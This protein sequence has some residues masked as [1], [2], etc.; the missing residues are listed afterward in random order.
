V[1]VFTWGVVSERL[2][3]ADVTA[4][5]VFLGIGAAMVGTDLGDAEPA[6]A[7]L[8]PL[9][10]ITLVWVLFSD[11]ARIR[12]RD[13]RRDA[14]YY[15]RLLGVGLPLSVGL[16][17]ALAGWLLPGQSVWLALLIGAALAPTDAA[18]GLPVVTNPAVP[19]RVRRAII[20]ESGLNDGIATPIVMVALAGAASTAGLAEAPT[21]TGAVLELIVGAAVG[22]AV[23]GLGGA[24]LR[25]GRRRGWVAEEFAGIAVLALA[26][27]AYGVTLLAG[28]NGFVA[29]F[30]GGV[31]FGAA[32]GRRASG[33]LE[34]IEQV[35]GVASL[36]VW[37]VF[38]AIAAPV[39]VESFSVQVAVYAVLSLTV[40][41]MLPVAVALAGGGVGRETV[42]F[43]GWFGPRGLASIV[44]ALIAFEELGRPA[45]ETLA[46]I[47]ATVVLSAVAHGLSAGPLVVRFGAA[48]AARGPGADVGGPEPAVR[49]LPFGRRTARRQPDEV[50][51]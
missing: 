41:R 21:L 19:A 46:V 6:T 34:F 24:L 25:A 23:G 31:G 9:A 50:G 47:A 38:G 51:Q 4:P 28:G 7:V 12:M 45:S 13:L 49:M 16:G 43:I 22:G 18:L 26:M 3:R 42:L 8:L 14:G 48:A 30:C 5:I 36:L 44:F 2:Q 11:A 20:V 17:W 39:L 37:L 15:V 40:V 10:E 29:A 27:A 35:G 1:S 32:A 33:E